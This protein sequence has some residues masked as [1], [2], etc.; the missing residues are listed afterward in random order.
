MLTYSIETERVRLREF[1]LNISDAKNYFII[2]RDEDI[3]KYL[4]YAYD[5]SI[6]DTLSTIDECFSRCDFVRDFY[7][8]IE[9]KLTKQMLGAII[10]TE[11]PFKP[12]NIEVCI[13]LGKQFR[14]QGYMTEA[15]NAFIRSLPK[16]KN[17]I[18]SIASENLD[19][20]KVVS[21]IEG[22]KLIE[23][24]NSNFKIY[25]YTT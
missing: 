25:T 9:D 8:V 22:I 3:Q 6:K 24:T 2:T 18:F 10:A 19:S 17:L 20:L 21:K 11:I 14:K 16:N 5:D 7:L 13:L 15:L 23:N 1:R 12:N 4:P